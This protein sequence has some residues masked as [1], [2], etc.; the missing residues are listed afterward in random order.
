MLTSCSSNTGGEDIA[1][2]GVIEATEVDIASK[3]AGEILVLMVNEG[4]RIVSAD[5]IAIID[6]S[7]LDLR[8]EHAEAG[9]ELAEAELKL[10]IE[11]ART[12]D[13]RKAEEAVKQ[14]EASMKM[15]E[16][17]LKRMD[18]LYESESIAKQMRDAAETQYKVALAQYNTAV[19]TL[20][21]MRQIARPE[22]IAAARAR[23]KQAETSSKLLRKEI[24]DCHVLSPIHGTVTQRLVEAGELVAQGT[25]I[26]TISQLDTVELT[27]Y[28]T[29]IELGRVRLG[30]NAEA[31]IDT[32][33]DRVFEGTIVYISPAAEF[34]PKNIQTKDDRVKLV[35]GVKIEI[36]NADGT[37]KPGM[38]ADATVITAD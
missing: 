34:T 11:G 30:Q 25:V 36:P 1:A 32:Y 5:T 6:H 21:K 17:D 19:Q 15:A 9:V 22:E 14:T 29:A 12:E 38:P 33:P 37:L 35:F 20:R 18:E 13:I 7:T 23:L 2:S 8:L 10:I 24:S 16:D 31:S 27:I 26:A 4:T 3:V 28:V